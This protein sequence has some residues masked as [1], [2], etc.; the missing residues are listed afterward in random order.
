[1]GRFVTLADIDG[2]KPTSVTAGVATST[3]SKSREN[4]PRRKS[5]TITPTSGII[6]LSFGDFDA[7]TTSGIQLQSGQTLNWTESLNGGDEDDASGWIFQGAIQVIGNGAGITVLVQE[8][9]DRGN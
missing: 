7:T 9:F 3:L 1:M 8:T 5:I 4:L 2:S 6:Y